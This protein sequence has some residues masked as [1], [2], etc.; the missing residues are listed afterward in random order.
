MNLE[1]HFLLRKEPIGILPIQQNIWLKGTEGS[2]L[3]P[4]HISL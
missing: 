1:K 3:Q 4:I 2:Y